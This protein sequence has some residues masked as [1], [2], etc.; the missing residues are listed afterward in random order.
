MSMAAPATRTAPHNGTAPRA[1]GPAAPPIRQS[2]APSV[3][4]RSRRNTGRI[5][6][7]VLVLVMSALG[8]V[9]L[10]SSAADRVAV[11]DD[12]TVKEITSADD[13]V[14]ANPTALVEPLSLSPS[15][16]PEGG[17]P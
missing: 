7:G 5:A 17:E 10:F 2:A 3:P 11:I 9:V 4:G 6:L 12:G 15:T 8:A 14:A 1:G 13:W 16:G